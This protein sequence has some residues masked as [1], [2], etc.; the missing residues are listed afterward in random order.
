[1]CNYI[2][3]ELYRNFNRIYLW[4]FSGV[5]ALGSILLNMIFAYMNHA[6]QSDIT[7]SMLLELGIMWLTVPMYISIGFIEITSSEEHKFLTFKNVIAGGLSRTKMYVGKMI[8]SVLL[9]F[10]A[11]AI[12]LVCFF[13]SGALL[14]GGVGGVETS[15]GMDFL[16]RLGTAIPL[17][18]A[19][20]A[21]GMALS[22]VITS[23]T[24]LGFVYIGIVS[25]VPT[26]CMVIEMLVWEGIGRVTD[27]TFMAQL[28]R[29]ADKM[30]PFTDWHIPAFLGVLQT[31]LFVAIGLSIVKK[32]RFK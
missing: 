15:L 23:P 8:T 2:K 5:F 13:G 31:L 17:W 18:I 6:Y 32:L 11:A 16:V 12:I 4:L 22:L 28:S 21:L 26:I 3:A 25:F 30:V 9:A 24:V 20:I 14:L 10:I 29:V 27:L 7:F 1:M 19:A